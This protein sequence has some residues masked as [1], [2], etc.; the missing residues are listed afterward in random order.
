MNAVAGAVKAWMRDVWS[1]WNRFWF[2]PALPHTLALIRILGGGMLFYT[3]L[4]WTLHLGHFLGPESWVT[5]D[6]S[7]T[8]HQ[9]TYAWTYWWLTDSPALMW[10][11]HLAALAIFAMLTIGLYT[12]VVSILAWLIA[13]AYCHRLVGAMFG[14]DQ[15]N[16]MLAMYLMIGPAGAAWSVDRW[17]ARRRAQAR[18]EKAP[19]AA[20][21]VSGNVAI[22]LLQLHLCVVY[23]FGGLGKMRGELWWDGSALWYALANLEYQSFS[24]TWLVRSPWLIALLSA[25]TM[26]WETFYCFLVWP[27]LTRPIALGMAV[28][29]HGGIALFMGMITFGVAMIFAN[30]AFVPPETTKAAVDWLLGKRRGPDLEAEPSRER[31]RD[32]KARRRA[33]PVSGRPRTPK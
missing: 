17:R 6:V 12:R 32:R 15:T 2:T 1:A 23:L 20:P 26:F 11:L 24:M 14:L 13:V 3:H 27:R 7:R 19:N 31:P 21:S 25:V 10:P 16:T 28:L 33:E 18:G 9:D 29:V 4:V 5:I 8:L 30:L 22:R